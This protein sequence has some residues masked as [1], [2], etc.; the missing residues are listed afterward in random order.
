MLSNGLFLVSFGRS[1]L[2]TIL[3]LPG[4]FHRSEARMRAYLIAALMLSGILFGPLPA[5]AAPLAAARECAQ[6]DT[7]IGLGRIV[8]IDAA[9]GPLFGVL[10]KQQN[11]PTFLREKEVV[12]TFDD[13]PSP[14]V[15][16]KILDTLER[17]CTKATFFSVGKMAVA[18]PDIARDII[19]RGHTLGGHTWSHPSQLP[20][21]PFDK[22]TEQ[23]ERGFAA[24]EAATG[25]G[26]APF[27]RFTGL[28]DSAR[29]LEYLQRRGVATF[30]VDVVSDDSFIASPDEIARLTLKRVE[31]RGGGI[32]LF[33][34]IKPATAKALP[35]ILDGLKQMGFRV[36]HLSYVQPI[37]ADPELVASYKETVSNKIARSHRTPRLLPFYGAISE[38]RDG[39]GPSLAAATTPVTRIAPEARNRQ[40]PTPTALKKPPEPE[41]KPKQR[42]APTLPE[43]PETEVLPWKSGSGARRDDATSNQ[44]PADTSGWN[45]SGPQA[46]T[47]GSGYLR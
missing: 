23:I 8:E 29:L 16:S 6:P 37:K 28:N 22:A 9:S 20:K 3:T 4:N 26:V 27:F 30:S 35:A 19:A 46:L 18:Y 44:Q 13:G 24:L 25:G 11:E 1:G 36:V 38:L 47:P 42:A 45:S 41:E 33:H 2:T 17:H 12:L 14:W 5:V 10:T 32:L 34:D 15:T 40:R 31:H 39:N 21:M 7:A 43:P